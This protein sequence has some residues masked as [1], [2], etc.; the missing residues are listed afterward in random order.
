[1]NPIQYTNILNI[2]WCPLL[3][4]CP[5]AEEVQQYEESEKKKIVKQAKMTGIMTSRLT[6]IIRGKNEINGPRK[7]KQW[8]SKPMGIIRGKEEVNRLGKPKKWVSKS[9]GLA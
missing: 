2:C 4:K 6:R 8:S 7:P 5:I 1:M 9:I 3:K